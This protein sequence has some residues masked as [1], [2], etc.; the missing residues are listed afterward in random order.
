MK[1]LQLRRWTMGRLFVM[2]P[3]ILATLLAALL[4][5][6][7]AASTGGTSPYTPPIKPVSKSNPLAAR[8][9]WIWELPSSSGGDVS[10][11]VSQARADGVRTLMIKSSDGTQMWSQFSAALVSELHAA[12]LKVCAWQY[13][14]GD[15]PSTEAALGAQAVHDGAD[16]LL[17][18]AEGEYE[19]K[20]VSAQTYITTLRRL[21]GPSYPVALAGLPYVDYHPAFPYSVFLGPGGAQYNA[22]QMYW[23]DI[24]T[25]TDGVFA[26]TYEFNL[27]YERPIFPL[28]QI[29]N[30]PPIHQVLRF[31]QLSRLYNAPGVSWWDWQE[32]TPQYFRAV[33]QP[34]GA[35]KGVAPYE[36]LATLG[37]GAQG[38]VVVWA[39][40]HLI[41]AGQSLTIDGD[42][43]PNTVA[44]V[45]AFQQA[46]G[47]PVTGE[48]DP[49]TWQ[50]LLRYPPVTV[51]WVIRKKKTV[52]VVAR[53]RTG[54][55]AVVATVPRS[56]SLP[57]RGRDIPLD[58]GAGT[59]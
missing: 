28:G 20:Y 10:A 1:F 17:I 19:G 36:T 2:W 50:A 22:P 35:L 32:G 14:Y 56:A 9:M 8:G 55:G 58:L 16:C 6:P 44:A 13:V 3:P 5:G 15:Q 31:R 12:G 21:I 46:K 45:D 54:A 33:S 40:E 53:A 49:P 37:A 11:I 25:T 51:K 38:D 57:D 7:G 34:V 39:Q 47:L 43:G 52:A 18:D 48:I 29:Y 23:H 41:S 26:H 30:S 42:Y 24:G 27:I 4:P 59:P